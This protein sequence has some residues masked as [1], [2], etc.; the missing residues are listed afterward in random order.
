MQ[1]PYRYLLLLTIFLLYSQFATAQNSGSIAP[2]DE[3]EYNMGTVGYKML[4]QMKVPLKEGYKVK[5]LASYEYGER[6][7]D[8]K[9]LFRPGQEK[10][11]AVIMVYSGMR[12]A[13][14]YYCIPTADAPEKLWDRYQKSLVGETENQQEQLRFFGFAL[15]KA[16]MFYVIK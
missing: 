9:G 8:F 10:P 15:A 14:E 13:P 7:A 11:C 5:D 4:M 1:T 12:G 16:M 3:E 6:K 2:T